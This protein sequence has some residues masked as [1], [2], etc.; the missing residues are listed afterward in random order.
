MN[1]LFVLDILGT[2]AFSLSGALK[3]IRKGF[4]IFGVIILGIIT[5]VGGGC[6]RDLMLGITP[7]SMLTNPVYVFIASVCS[8]LLFI[9]I[10]F[11]LKNKKPSDSK[12]VRLFDNLYFIMDTVGLA[13]FT[14][15]GELVSYAYLQSPSMFITV[16]M[17]V[18]TGIGGGILRDITANELPSVFVKHVYATSS[19]AGA[20]L[21]AFLYRFINQNTAMILGGVLIIVM[22]VLAA[23]YKWELPSIKSALK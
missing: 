7:P 13:A 5:A 6:M 9:V 11:H 19:L 17:G 2:V 3:A 15:D 20:L 21:T 16:F 1:I 18:I 10:S 4:D 22:R 8:V 12:T 14:L 23:H